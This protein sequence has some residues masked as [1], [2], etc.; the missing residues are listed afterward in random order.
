MLSKVKD[1][2]LNVP[3]LQPEIKHSALGA[4]CDFRGNAFLSWVCLL[5]DLKAVGVE[6][7]PEQEK[8]RQQV[9]A[10]RQAVL[11]LGPSDPAYL[12]PH[13]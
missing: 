9:Q 10:A 7:V 1:T 6:W 2:L 5:S 12:K 13:A 4:S 3:H 8:A 11:P